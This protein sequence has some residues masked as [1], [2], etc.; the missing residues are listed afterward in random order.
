[1]RIEVDIPD[2]IKINL[3]NGYSFEI[4]SE[5]KHLNENNDGIIPYIFANITVPVKTPGIYKKNGEKKVLIEEVDL[6]TLGKAFS[7]YYILEQAI[8]DTIND[9]IREKQKKL[10]FLEDIEVGL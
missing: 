5:E 6:E 1:M 10:K 7:S 3:G 4:G 2:N 8:S 9:I